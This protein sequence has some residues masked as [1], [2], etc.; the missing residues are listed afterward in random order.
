MGVAINVSLSCRARD[1]R[2]CLAA[3]CG[4]IPVAVLT[5]VTMEDVCHMVIII[6]YC[7]ILGV[8]THRGISTLYVCMSTLYV[9][10]GMCT[11]MYNYALQDPM[12]E[13]S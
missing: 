10:Y 1:S 5:S 12:I 9:T 8:C 3:N 2:V 11:Y 13:K 4:V 6:I 7:E